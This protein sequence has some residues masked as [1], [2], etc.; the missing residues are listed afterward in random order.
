MVSLFVSFTLTPM[1]CAGSSVERRGRAAK[2]GRLYRGGRARYGA[3]LALVAAAPLGGRRCCR[4]AIV[5]TT[6][7]LLRHGRQDVPPA[8]RP[9]R[10]RG[11]RS[12]TPGGYTLDRDGRVRRDRGARCAKLRGVT[13][14]LT[15]IGDTTGRSAGRGRRDRGSIYVQLVDLPER[16][17]SQFDVMARRPADARRLSRPAHQRAGH[18][19]ARAAAA[20]ASPTSRS[21]C[22]AP[23]STRSGLHLPA[24]RPHAHDARAA[25]TSTP[26]SRSASPSCALV[27]DREH[28]AD[29]GRQRR[30]RRRDRADL[31]RRAS[32]SRSSRRATSSTTS[33]CAPSRP[34]ERRRRRS[35]TSTVAS[36]Q[37]RS[38]FRLGNFIRLQR[39]R[40]ARP[41]RAPEPPAHDHDRRQPRRRAA[42]R[43]GRRTPRRSARGSTCR[44]ATTSHGRPRQG[45]RRDGANFI[46]AFGSR[47]SSC[48]WCWPRSSRASRPD[49]DPAGAA[50]DVPLRPALALAA[51]RAAG[52]LRD[53]RPVHAR[54]HRQEERHPP[55]RLHQQAARRRAC[56]ATRRSS[57]PTASRLR[58]IL[59]TT[60]MLVPAWSRSPSARAPARGPR[61]HGQ[62]H[63]R[64]PDAL[65]PAHPPDHPGRLRPVR[66][67]GPVAVGAPVRALAARLVPRPRSG[68]SV[69]AGPEPALDRGYWTPGAGLSAMG[70]TPRPRM[71]APT[72][73]R[74]AWRRPGR[75]RRGA[76]SQADAASSWS[77]W[78]G[79]QPAYPSSRRQRRRG[80]SSGCRLEQWPQ[81]VHGRGEV[82]AVAR[83]AG[84]ARRP[85]RCRGSRKPRLVSTGPPVHSRRPLSRFGGGSS[86][87]AL[88]AWMSVGRL[89]TKPT[90]PSGPCSQSRT[91]ERLKFGSRSCGIASSRDGAR[92]G[93]SSAMWR[94]FAVDRGFVNQGR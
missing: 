89:T 23:T 2:G 5:L 66:R 59:M 91:T 82:E 9:E 49:H 57:R 83:R 29:L 37:R 53:L 70:S 86:A 76:V 51:G 16:D 40:R 10:V 85:G 19:P 38:S 55:G 90:A 69:R 94:C 52:H 43:G 71:A 92:D 61:S 78:P 1:L 8:G 28:A 65:A 44:R 81:D 63:H 75:D 35:P 64:R 21:T 31:G 50:A 12:A 32:R 47:W 41:D 39:G 6:V 88:A 73:P 93:S 20:R 62:R 24:D 7:P 34:A 33:G 17:F 3:V 58:P 80:S 87:T 56:R 25:S 26:P 22:S 42:R 77:S 60:L 54:R 27:I 14:L 18:Q 30:G 48:T 67:P 72:S 11:H 84:S 13:N 45:P 15:T 36:P 46:L 4:S 79:P 68:R 74:R